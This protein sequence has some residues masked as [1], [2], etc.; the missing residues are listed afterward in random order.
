MTVGA[1][2][3]TLAAA[4][5]AA[6]AAWRSSR[7]ATRQGIVPPTR[8]TAWPAVTSRGLDVALAAVPLLLGAALTG[9]AL[10]VLGGA[11][12]GLLGHTVAWGWLLALGLASITGRGWDR[13]GPPGPLARDRPLPARLTMLGVWPAAS[14]LALVGLLWVLTRAAQG[15]SRASVAA[16]LLLAWLAA[17]TALGRLGGRQSLHHADPLTAL[18]TVVARLAPLSRQAE[19]WV[20]R[21]PAAA[22]TGEEP[23]RGTLALAAAALAP[24]VV[25]LAPLPGL[26]A[27]HDPVTAV[28][29]LT[30]ALLACAV[31]LRLAAIRPYLLP[32]TLPGVAGW[33][34]AGH[35]TALLP[36][37][38]LPR[39]AAG[40]LAAAVLLTGHLVTIAAAHRAALAR[41][42]PRAARAVQFPL[43][44]VALLSAAAGVGWAVG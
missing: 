7:P 40:A 39:G 3:A 4:T 37:L 26:T 17:T 28:G 33:V 32:A 15:H 44:A 9:A 38:G 6:S 34:L 18:T 1:L 30:L 11:P 27:E 14:A 5:V 42:D 19:G 16:G 31:L 24:A 29:A 21:N 2:A 10:A 12:A 36:A 25:A 22:R 8:M 41:F 43:R 13:L 20:W 35:L 23:P